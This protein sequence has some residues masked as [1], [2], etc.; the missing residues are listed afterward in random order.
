VPAARVGDAVLRRIK[1]LSYLDN[2]LAQRAAS[3][4]SAHEAILLDPDGCVVEGA[5]RNVFAVISGE[6]ITPPTSRGFLPGITRE[7]VLEVAE[8]QGVPRAERELHVSALYGAE[9]CFLT[10]SIAEILPV[11][12]VDGRALAE[13][14]PGPIT[15]QMS[16]AYRDLV[17]RELQPPGPGG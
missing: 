14:V 4:R 2:L 12:S 8:Q 15:A 10:S 9:E 1:S 11:A 6:L 13:P 3:A 17:A 16:S 5:M 7:T